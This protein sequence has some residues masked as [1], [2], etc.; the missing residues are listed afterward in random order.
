[1]KSLYA[2]FAAMCVA[3]SLLPTQAPAQS[4]PSRPV[5]ILVGSPPGGSLDYVSRMISDKMAEAL[6]QPIVIENRPGADS[7]IAAN[8]VAQSKPDGYSLIMQTVDHTMMRH[9][10]KLPYDPFKDF[11]YLGEVARAPL[12]MT[13]A[14]ASEFSTFPEF[15][16]Y[17][18]T[19]G[20][21]LNYGTSGEGGLYHYAAQLLMKRAGFKATK[22]PYKG[23]APMITGTIS[24]EVDF[25]FMTKTFYKIHRDRLKGIAITSTER[26]PDLPEIEPINDRFGPFEM[27]LGVGLMGPAGLPE[28]VKRKLA[29]AISVATNDPGTRKRIEDAGYVVIGSSPAEHAERVRSQAAFFEKL[30]GIGNG[31]SN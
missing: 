22:I 10:M 23:G 11:D 13:T 26:A 17:A 30:V 27:A 4:Y 6:G 1:M 20:D 28:S 29:N 19:H 14:N 12:V 31:Q 21:T 18:K 3:L 24:K 8:R 9:T 16:A 7:T 25:S 5:T 2:T 15:L